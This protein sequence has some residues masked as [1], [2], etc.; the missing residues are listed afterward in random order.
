MGKYRN[1]L[2]QEEVISLL[3]RQKKG[4]NDFNIAILDGMIANL[5]KGGYECNAI[6]SNVNGSPIENL[7]IPYS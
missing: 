6:M 3:E 2:T 5:Q 7:S 4:C 1:P